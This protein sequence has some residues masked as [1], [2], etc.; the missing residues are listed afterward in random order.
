M[1]IKFAIH[2]IIK[3]QLRDSEDD[4]FVY[5]GI[6]GSCCLCLISGSTLTAEGVVFQICNNVC[7]CFLSWIYALAGIIY[8][9]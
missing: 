5:P 6:S 9:I 3:N 2:L 4:T 1:Q 8:Q 7:G